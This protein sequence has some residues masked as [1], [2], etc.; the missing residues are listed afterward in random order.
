MKG[1]SA[2]LMTVGGQRI[3]RTRCI[4]LIEQRDRSTPTTPDPGFASDWFPAAERQD[5]H[6]SARVRVA[7]RG[8]PRLVAD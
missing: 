3:R 6:R 2:P 7:D 4:S 5:E 1:A 8:N